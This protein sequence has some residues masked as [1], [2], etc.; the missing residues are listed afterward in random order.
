MWRVVRPVAQ[1]QALRTARRHF[2]G[3]G[4]TDNL[5]G[6]LMARAPLLTSGASG[7]VL[8]ALGDLAAQRYEAMSDRKKRLAAGE[9][10]HEGEP[11]ELKRTCGTAFHG[12]FVAG[13]GAYK[14][15]TFMDGVVTNVFK[16]T[17]G[18]WN[19]AMWDGG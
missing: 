10:E 3:G 1:T 5:Y 18:K 13:V 14:W 2:S 17:P 11:L 9:P 4:S 15:Y 6:R 8:W 16:F 19:S 12:F 7:A